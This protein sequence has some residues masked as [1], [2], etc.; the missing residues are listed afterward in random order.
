MLVQ[1]LCSRPGPGVAADGLQLHC[2]DCFPLQRSAVA[3]AA[4]AGAGAHSALDMWH[5]RPHWEATCPN[6][7]IFAPCVLCLY[8]FTYIRYKQ[9]FCE[10][11]VKC[12]YTLEYKRS[13]LCVTFLPQCAAAALVVEYNMWLSSV[14]VELLFIATMS[15]HWPA[16]WSSRHIR[17]CVNIICHRVMKPQ[18]CSRCISTQ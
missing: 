10:A 3:A 5:D 14:C 11:N 4:R 16:Q 15:D 12:R 17:C 6:T 1:L 9:W 8:L 2:R 18:K 13:F 7:F